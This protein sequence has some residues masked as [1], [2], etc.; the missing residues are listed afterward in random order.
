M[1]T[2]AARRGADDMTSLSGFV[3]S[4]LANG[5]QSVG[6]IFNSS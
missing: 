1:L 4:A 3:S 6:S 2:A 5:S